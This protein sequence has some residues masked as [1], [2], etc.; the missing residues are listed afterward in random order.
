M[1]WAKFA[2]LHKVLLNRLPPLVSFIHVF[3]SYI[4]YCLGIWDH[5]QLSTFKISCRANQHS[6][7]YSHLG[8]CLAP[9]G[10]RMSRASF[11]RSC[12]PVCLGNDTLSGTREG[13][14][15]YHAVLDRADYRLRLFT[16]ERQQKKTWHQLEQ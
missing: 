7:F 16:S 10:L 2:I 9:A 3:R 15:K 12:S 13:G 1:V 8:I 4:L 14:T 5:F 6:A 11:F